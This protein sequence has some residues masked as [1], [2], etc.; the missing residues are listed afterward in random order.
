[1]TRKERYILKRFHANNIPLIE[2]D[3]FNTHCVILDYGDNRYD[4]YWY[5]YDIVEKKYLTRVEIF[6]CENSHVGRT[7]LQNVHELKNQFSRC[8]DKLNEV[9]KEYIEMINQL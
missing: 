7:F 2:R 8:V 3:L 9:D 4:P 5:V 6:H 1:M